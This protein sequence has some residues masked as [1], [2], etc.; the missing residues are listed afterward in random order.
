MPGLNALFSPLARC[1]SHRRLPYFTR[2][3]YLHEIRASFTYPLAAA[4]AEG[5]FASV[6]AQKYFGASALLIAVI[7]AAPM[8]GNV[9]AIVWADLAER[10]P[11]VRFVNTLQLGVIL[12]TSMVALTAFLPR[13]AGAWTF[14]GLMVGARM[15]TSGIVTAKN[16][17]W[18]FNFPKQKRGLIV[19]RVNMIGHAMFALTTFA[20]S[21]V[22]D[23]HPGAYIWVYLAC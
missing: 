11:K 19:G 10:R 14:A 22:L 20:G 15:F 1:F 9:L 21:F 5:S 16:L 7:V 17:I 4:M 13:E 6:V 12:C 18:R 23:Q 3:N 8:F 2:A